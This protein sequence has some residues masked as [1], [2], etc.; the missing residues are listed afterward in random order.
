MQRV[1]NCSMRFMYGVRRR[2]SIGHLYV[3]NNYLLLSIRRQR[4][5][6]VLFYKAVLKGEGPEYIAEEFKRQVNVHCHLTRNR[7]HL[8][9]TPLPRSRAITSSF[10]SRQLIY[11]TRATYKYLFG[12]PRLTSIGGY[13]PAESGRP[14]DRPA[15]RAVMRRDRMCACL[16]VCES[17]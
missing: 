2:E 7:P 14:H 12:I 15:V 16:C 8:F 17:E 5:M 13:V 3:D 9:N 1:Q 6:L 4:L 11:G 10:T